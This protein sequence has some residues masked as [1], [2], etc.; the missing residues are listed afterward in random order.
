M[1]ALVTGA[2]DAV[3]KEIMTVSDVMCWITRSKGM[4][5]VALADHDM[6]QL[7]Q[8]MGFQKIMCP[9]NLPIDAIDSFGDP[10]QLPCPGA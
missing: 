10:F 3:K 1:V 5:E 8:E 4:T 7:V 2:G 9:Q 6:T